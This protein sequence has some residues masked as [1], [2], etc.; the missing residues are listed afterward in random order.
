MLYLPSWVTFKLLLL[1]LQS[2]FGFRYV[3]NMIGTL[4]YVLA[5]GIYGGACP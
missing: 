2:S 3:H 1:Y 5:I 4:H